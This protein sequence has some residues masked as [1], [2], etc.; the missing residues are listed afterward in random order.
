MT[1][2]IVVL[3]TASTEDEAE[4]IAKALVEKRLCACV[5]M[6]KEIRSFFRWE[7]KISDE[8]EVLLIAKSKKA[9]FEKIEKEIKTLHSYTMPEIIALPLISGSKEYLNWIESETQ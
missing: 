8:G 1:E 6:A 7:G 9:N 2:Y 4:K 3:I 5:N